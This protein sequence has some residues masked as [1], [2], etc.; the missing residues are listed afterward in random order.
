M[1][2]GIYLTNSNESKLVLNALSWGKCKEFYHV[3]SMILSTISVYCQDA[4]VTQ[5]LDNFVDS[6][7]LNKF[8]FGNGRRKNV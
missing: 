8:V 7:F 3:N 6:Y 1:R 5:M 2:E 4:N